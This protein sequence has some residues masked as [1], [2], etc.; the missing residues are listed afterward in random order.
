LNEQRAELD[1][2]LHRCQAELQEVSKKPEGESD[3]AKINRLL[4][5]QSKLKKLHKIKAHVKRQKKQLNEKHMR[6]SKKK[7][8]N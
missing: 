8:A 2:L 6:Q 3:G 5:V 1:S 7:K 4:L